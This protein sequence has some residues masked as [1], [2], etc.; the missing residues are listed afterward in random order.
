M[1]TPEAPPRVVVANIFQRDLKV[2][3]TLLAIESHD[4]RF[5]PI[6]KFTVSRIADVELAALMGA[7]VTAVR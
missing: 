7:T 1:P 3:D 6:P 2:G 4:S 5:G